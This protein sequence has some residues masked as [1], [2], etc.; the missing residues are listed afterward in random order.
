MDK[1]EWS[2]LEYEE[3]HRG[4]DWFWALG[5]I[6]LTSSLAAVIFGNYFFAILIVLSGVLLGYFAIKKPDLVHY[7]LNGQGLK[8]RSRLYLYEDINSFWVQID[9]TGETNLKPTFFI[10]T[11]RVFMPNI[12]IPIDDA[13]APEIRS[14]MIS[15]NVPEVEMREHPSEKIIESLGF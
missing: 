10:K 9:P 1:L 6:V 12:S 3:K 5:V 13:M 8:I 4:P 2:A 11:E 7:E 14:I 15:N